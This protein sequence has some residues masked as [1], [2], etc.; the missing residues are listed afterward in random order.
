M[1]FPRSDTLPSVYRAYLVSSTLQSCKVS[2]VQS[3]PINKAYNVL[4]VF[5]ISRRNMKVYWKHPYKS[6]AV[7]LYR[8]YWELD[9]LSPLYIMYSW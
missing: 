2:T 7:I 9:T 1:L 8:V 6:N 3:S 4:N 5:I